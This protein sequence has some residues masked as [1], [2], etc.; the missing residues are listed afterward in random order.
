LAIRRERRPLR[1][2]EERDFR[3]MLLADHSIA[4][5]SLG[6]GRLFFVF[7]VAA[8]TDRFVSIARLS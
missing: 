5:E 6:I 3:T 8:V 2:T 1:I 7:L 4:D